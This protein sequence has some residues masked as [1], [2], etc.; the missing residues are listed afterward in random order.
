VRHAAHSATPSADAAPAAP[1]A[2]T[3]P[4]GDTITREPYGPMAHRPADTP[5]E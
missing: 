4:A 3:Q 2:L 1:Q 5:G